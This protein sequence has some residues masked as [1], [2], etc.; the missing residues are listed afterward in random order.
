MSP[1]VAE[2]LIVE[3]E[4]A[5]PGWGSGDR[6]AIALGFAG[7][8]GERIPSWLYAYKLLATNGVLVVAV[9]TGAG[10]KAGA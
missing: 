5:R 4:A 3:L 8:G 9:T 7:E 10:A 6:A 1:D 2:R